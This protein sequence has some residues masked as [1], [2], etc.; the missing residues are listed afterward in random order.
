GWP[1]LSARGPRAPA[2]P[3]RGAVGRRVGR[4]R[5]RVDPGGRGWGERRQRTGRL[6]RSPRC[7]VA[8][9]DAPR[10]RL[11]GR[12]R[13]GPARMTVVTFGELLL[14]L[15]PP[16]EER[17]LESP[18]LHTCFGGA[19]A[20]VAVALRHLGVPSSYITRLP[21]GPLGNEGLDALRREG[22]AVDRVLRGGSRLG[23]YF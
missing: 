7:G 11:G 2:L 9:A 19:E 12:G 14:R 5:G 4:E 22:V 23:L 18:V 6:G 16:G 13:R 21:E 10:R 3:A 17:L 1:P 15:S 8:R 20:N